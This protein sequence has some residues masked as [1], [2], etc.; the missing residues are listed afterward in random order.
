MWGRKSFR[1]VGVVILGLGVVA[2]SFVEAAAVTREEA[3]ELAREGE[4]DS[5][6]SALR[7]LL[8]TTPDD[9]L[10]RYDLAIILTWVG[11]NR[12]A[13]DAFE[14]VNEAQPPDYVLAPIIRAYRDQKRFAEAERWARTAQERS[15]LD[16]TWAKLLALVLTDQDQTREALE[17]LEPWAVAR[18]DD[19]ELWLALGYASLRSKDRFGAL[20][21]YGQAL[22]LQPENREAMGAMA[23]ML[24]ELGA[25]M[26]AARYL[27]PV[28]IAVQANQ[29][30]ELVRWGHDVTPPD[31]R[32]R[33]EG[34][35]KALARLNQLLAQA[36]ASRKPDQSLIIRL[37]RDRVL[38]L[39]NREQWTE[40]MRETE[41]L[42]TDGDVVPP[43]VREAEADAL[44]ASRRPEEAR[45]GY[46]EVLRADPTVREAQIGRFFALVEEEN[47]SAAFQQTD[48]IAAME[49]PGAREPK[50]AVHP[51]DKWLEAKVLGAEARSFADMPGAAWEMLLSLAEQAPANIELRRVLGDIAG[52]RG[53]PRRSAEE[54]EI[55][56]SLVPEDKA[57]QISLAESDIRRRHWTEAHSRIADLAA[58]YPNDVHV[59]RIEN[60]LRAHDDFELQT[61]FHINKEYGG[62]SSDTNP[63]GNSPGSGTDWTARL[64]SPPVAE[65]WRVLGAWEHHTAKTTDGQALRYRLGGG[66]E[67]ALPDLTLE[68]IAWSNQGDISEPGASLGVAW[69]PTDHWRFDLGAELFAGDTPLRAVLNNITANS[70]SVGVTYAW[71]E[72]RS[73]ALGVSGYDFSDG[74]RRA[75]AHLNLAQKVVDIPHFDVTLRPE[76]YASTNTSSTGPYFSP[77][78]DLSGALTCDVEH[79]VWRRYERSFSHRL[80]VTGGAYWQENFGTSWIGSILYEQVFQY[81]PWLDLRWGVLRKRAVYDGA[82]TPSTEGFVRFNLRF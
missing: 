19:A 46:D 3:V 12:E 72:S 28:P 76:I 50:Q 64:Y 30:G 75:A 5:A 41:A 77:S 37:R 44:L 20:R 47:F 32:R 42:R 40:A 45:R 74:N 66:V 34:T 59:G 14:K 29:A 4:T 16:A 11:R 60:D 1:T 52:G 13:T 70:A 53:W 49:N 80:A 48:D 79:V 23:G 15:S 63:T 61:E 26:A 38:A 56:V 27:Q 55:A 18:P 35:D 51:N 2:G 24:A 57:A 62:N 9:A 78:R 8:A 22:R 69:L 58:I 54:I 67:L 65:F 43:Y 21:A 71:H 10:A 68:A 73:L 36:R 7:E 33:F 81:N 25:P 17:L 39:R 6:I 82:Q 31:P